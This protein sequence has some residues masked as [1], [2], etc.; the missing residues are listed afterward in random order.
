MSLTETVGRFFAPDGTIV[1]PDNL[2][3]PGVCEA[4]YQADKAAGGDNR[5]VIRFWDYSASRDGQVIDID[6]GTVNRRIKAVAARLQQVASIGE[7]AAILMGNHPDYIYAFLGAMYAG[8]VPVPLY[9][10]TEPGHAAHL[11]AVLD[12]CRP[13]VV[14]TN[15]LSAAAVRRTFA[16]V[17]AGKR[18]RILAVDALPDSLADSWV[19]P[20]ETDAGRAVARNL[21]EAGKKPKDQLAFLQYTS[22]STRMPAGVLLTHSS[23]MTNA[24]QIYV[25]AQFKTPQRMVSWLPMHHDMGIVL[26]IMF[27][28]FGMPM[29]IMRPRD[30]IQQPKRFIRQLARR[31]DN[32]W[33]YTAV[34]NFALGLAVRYGLPDDGE[35]IDLSNVDNLILG[36][37][38]VMP[39]SLDAFAEAFAPYGF[40]RHALR[41]S[42]GQTEASL[43]LTTP[44]TE[45][46]PIIVAVDREALTRDEIK[47]V[48]GDGPLTARL[49]SCGPPIPD[50]KVIIVDPVTRRELDDGL[51]GEIWGWG[52]NVAAGY[53]NRPEDTEATFCN[54]LAG[55]RAH[56]SRAA[57]VPDDAA[58]LSTGDL[59]CI[60]DGE[61]FLT[62]RVKEL[63]VIAGRNHYP[64][65]IEWT[66]TQA[67]DHLRP[68]CMAAFAIPGDDVEQLVILAEREPEA[69]PSGD[70][71]AI[72]AV[73]TAVTEGHGI[74]PAEIIVCEPDTIARSSSGKIA[75]RLVRQT[76]LAEH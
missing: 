58:W 2:T 45:N 3:L 25:A 35:E 47:R 57:G 60:L 64:L 22:G 44:Q 72:D 48:D 69:D 61:L 10:P 15:Q 7:K 33:A 1:L 6:R 56:D 68:A 65:D 26:A 46:R 27:T 12:D 66:A 71:A 76:Y 18:P 38:P 20:A 37:E 24:L 67:T 16:S 55:K 30:F 13:Q 23:V 54:T 63:I 41:P 74:S 28:I 36:A 52:N 39:R 43:L 8:M 73:R 49:V 14:M 50:E 11:A 29:D 40:H 75:R 31:A 34:P 42:F 17:P 4:I 9:D 53:Y 21:A 59:G 62:G 70:A 32:D 19:N 51:V 5:Q